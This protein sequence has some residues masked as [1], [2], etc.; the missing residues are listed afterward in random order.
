MT[1]SWEVVTFSHIMTVTWEMEELCV[2]HEKMCM[3]Y[4]TLNCTL[5]SKRKL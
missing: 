1:A 2:V 4:P 3:L 5:L